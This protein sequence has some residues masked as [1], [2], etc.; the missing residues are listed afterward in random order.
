[1]RAQC[2]KLEALHMAGYPRSGASVDELLRR[3]NLTL[4]WVERDDAVVGFALHAKVHM[5]VYVL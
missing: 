1:M 4:V 3:S 5:R 2:L